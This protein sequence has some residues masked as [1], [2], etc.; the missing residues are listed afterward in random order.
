MINF[1]TAPFRWFFKLESASGL[2]LLIAAIVA[3][4]L[5]NSD[6]G[7]H[8]FN[9][10]DKEILIG[11]QNFGLSLTVLHWIND[12]LMCVFFF[13]VTL[14]IKREFVHGELSNPK[15]AALPIIGAVGGMAVPAIIYIIIN[16]G[17]DNTLRGWAIPSVHLL[18]FN[19]CIIFSL[20]FDQQIWNK[21]IHTLLINRILS[22]VFYTRVWNSFHNIRCNFSINNTS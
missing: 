9:I 18:N 7:E 3:L 14:E 17:G 13:V 22:L 4:L 12:V 16:L 21:K 10:L 15:K 8:Y 5:S 6:F 1:I 11:I 2:I 19:D 20:S